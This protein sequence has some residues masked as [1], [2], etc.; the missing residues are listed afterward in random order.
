MEHKKLHHTLQTPTHNPRLL[1]NSPKKKKRNWIH[2]IVIEF[3]QRSIWGNVLCILT[4]MLISVVFW[5]L[6]ERAS[7]DKL[8][9]V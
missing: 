2:T 1:Y 3:N 4:S 7:K 5:V 8:S 9:K 6:F